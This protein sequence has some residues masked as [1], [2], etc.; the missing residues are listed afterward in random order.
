MLVAPKKPIT[1][2]DPVLGFGDENGNANM[3]IIDAKK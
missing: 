1:G 2:N 3:A